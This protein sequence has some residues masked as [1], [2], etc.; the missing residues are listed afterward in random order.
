MIDDKVE[1]LNDNTV[2]RLYNLINDLRS[3]RGGNSEKSFC[4]VFSL[5][6]SDKAAILSNYA[7]LFKMCTLGI[8][9]IEQ[10]KPKNV[11]RHI[12]TLNNVIE[13]LSLIYFNAYSDVSNNG[14]E[15]FKKHFDEAL[16]I[17]LGYCADY[18]SEHSNEDVIEDEKIQ[19][20]IKEINE[21][22]DYVL[23]CKLNVEL[24]KILT[25]QLN[26]VRESLL[27]YK[28]YGSSGVL[29]SISTTLGALILNREKVDSSNA[30]DIVD[31]I[32]Y[33][34]GRINTI[35]S[36][37]NNSITLIGTIYKKLTGKE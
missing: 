26:N 27:K 17:S 30:M 12:A 35:I 23:E 37:N 11:S 36:F 13:G 1:I 20:L 10:L 32:F 18:L 8:S 19:E 28:F 5:D 9:Q 25:Y 31:K 4:K 29:N 16:M 6:E 7:E 33:V 2:G 15:E 24:E 22:I 34:M 3:I 14:M 21:V